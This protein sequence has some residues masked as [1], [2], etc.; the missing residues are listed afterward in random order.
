MSHHIFAGGL[1]SHGTKIY[2]IDIVLWLANE[3]DIVLGEEN[4]WN[5]NMKKIIEIISDTTGNNVY[6]ILR[7]MYT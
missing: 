3:T 2:R 7:Y 1:K 4:L 5:R 6:N